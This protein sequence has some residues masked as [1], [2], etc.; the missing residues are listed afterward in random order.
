MWIQTRSAEEKKTLCGSHSGRNEC[1]V[2]KNKLTHNSKN[3]RTTASCAY[4]ILSTQERRNEAGERPV[5]ITLHSN[6]TTTFFF[7]W[8]YR[9]LDCDWPEGR[10]G[11]IFYN[12]SSD[13]NQR[14][15]SMK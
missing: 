11:V 15:I 1:V 12:S 8:C 3:K 6:Y 4:I 13:S 7:S 10:E 14:F 5:H 2:A 9:V